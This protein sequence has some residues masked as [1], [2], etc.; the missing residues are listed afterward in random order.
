M[1]ESAVKRWQP[2][3]RHP[4]ILYWFWAPEILENEKYLRDLEHISRESCYTMVALS[5]RDGMDFFDPS[6]IPHFEKAVAAA[7]ERGLHFFLHSCGDNSLLLD[8]LAASGLDVLHPIQKGCMDLAR[9]VEQ[10]G[11][12]LSF[13]VGMDVQHLLVNGTPQ[14]VRDELKGIKSLFAGQK[15]GLLFAMGNGIM[16]GTPLANIRA[17]MEEMH[18]E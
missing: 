18:A 2:L 7:H 13:L 9:T 12:R 17:A 16:P 6:L 4:R 3:S 8:D 10:C 14:E 11:D 5:A 15:G 1:N